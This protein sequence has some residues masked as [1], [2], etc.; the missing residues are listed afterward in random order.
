MLL[1]AAW[2]GRADAT[3]EQQPPGLAALMQQPAE[4]QGINSRHGK[5][6]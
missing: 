6:T 4:N 5:P 2:P 1:D 3:A